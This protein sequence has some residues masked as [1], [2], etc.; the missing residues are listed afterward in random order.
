MGMS[1]RERSVW[2]TIEQQIVCVARPTFTHDEI[3]AAWKPNRSLRW[4]FRRDH[5]KLRETIGAGQPNQL[6]GRIGSH[7]TIISTIKRDCADRERAAKIVRRANVE[8]RE[9][10]TVI[11]A[12]QRRRA[13]GTREI[14]QVIEQQQ[15]RLFDRRRKLMF[16]R[17][18]EQEEMQ[19]EIG[20]SEEHTSELQS[21]GLTSYA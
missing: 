12:K 2:A 20:R 8:H 15:Q 16:V 10:S 11:V 9:T 3:T 21:R 5:I 18:C 4:F 6:L 19:I 7:K 1:A 14:H 17:A 13:V